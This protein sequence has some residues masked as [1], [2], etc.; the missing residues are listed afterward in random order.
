MILLLYYTIQGE[1]KKMNKRAK[2]IPVDI[3]TMAVTQKIE[4][5][6]VLILVLDGHKGK[7]TLTQ[8]VEHGLTSVETANGKSVRLHYDEKELI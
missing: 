5:G 2:E 6:K 8:A 4:S 7:A 1:Q 3:T